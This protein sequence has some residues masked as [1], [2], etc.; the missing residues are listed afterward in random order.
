MTHHALQIFTLFLKLLGLYYKTFHSRNLQ[1]FV[2]SL[3]CLSLPSLSSLVE[4][5][6]VRPGAYPTVEDL[7]GASLG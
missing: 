5:L 6:W 3:E 2:I 7:K 4:C 1:I